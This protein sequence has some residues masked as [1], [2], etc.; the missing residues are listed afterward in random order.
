[1]EHEQLGGSGPPPAC[2]TDADTEVCDDEK[3]HYSSG[4]KSSKLRTK[5]V[6]KLASAKE[7]AAQQRRRAEAA[8]AQLAY[9]GRHAK[10]GYTSDGDRPSAGAQRAV[11]KLLDEAAEY[12]GKSTPE[13]VRQES[14]EVGAA[15]GAKAARK[16]LKAAEEAEGEDTEGEDHRN[17]EPSQPRSRRL[18]PSF[19]DAIAQQ[20]KLATPFK[21]PRSPAAYAEAILKSLTD[22]LTTCTTITPD[23]K[24]DPLI[25][26]MLEPY[27]KAIAAVVKKADK[28]RKVWYTK[29]TEGVGNTHGIHIK[30]RE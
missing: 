5:K 19:K 22:G 4:T 30:R 2:P 28:D 26:G 9:I 11:Q 25:K 12:A 10:E 8:E 23:A 20:R 18:K 29:L 24:V 1:M 13:R 15:A 17:P 27:A 14:R 7:E 3:S 6:A 21:I 16:V